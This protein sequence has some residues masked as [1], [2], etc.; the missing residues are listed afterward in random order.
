MDSLDPN[1]PTKSSFKGNI[2][3]KLFVTELPGDINEQ[4]LLSIFG[5]F[6]NVAEIKVVSEGRNQIHKGMLYTY[7]IFISQF[8]FV[9]CA[10]VS[11]HS[12]ASAAIAVDRLHGKLRFPTVR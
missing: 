6:G 7:F 10:F 8:N 11:Y 3:G 9:G 1:N 2:P 12:P 4:E 5:E